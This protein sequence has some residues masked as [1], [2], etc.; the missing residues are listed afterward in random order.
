MYGSPANAT[1]LPLF[2]LEPEDDIRSVAFVLSVHR[3]A[4]QHCYS[5]QRVTSDSQAA[6]AAD[7]RVSTVRPATVGVRRLRL[8]RRYRAAR[9]VACF[10][11]SVSTFRMY[12]CRRGPSKDPSGRSVLVYVVVLTGVLAST[13]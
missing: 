9:S 7:P 3:C 4:P 13:L 11:S 12:A 5:K 6:A 2:Y 8:L 1:K 10:F